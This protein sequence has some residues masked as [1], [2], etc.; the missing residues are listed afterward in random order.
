MT[1][2]ELADKLQAMDQNEYLAF[3]HKFGGEHK[4]PEDFVE[5]FVR[6]PEHERLIAHMLD[7]PT[8]AEKQTQASLSAA[9][10]AKWAA[11]CAF[12]SALI[13]LASLIY[14]LS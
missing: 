1:R 12:V 3:L 7:L 2:E 4:I 11:I 8:E 14:M 9:S 13:A 5:H 6:H 10:A